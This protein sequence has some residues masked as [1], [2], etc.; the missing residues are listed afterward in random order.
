[1]ADVQ[2]E[3]DKLADVTRHTQQHPEDKVAGQGAV[4]FVYVGSKGPAGF[5]AHDF[6]QQRVKGKTLA[7]VEVVGT[8]IEKTCD[9]SGTKEPYPCDGGIPEGGLGKNID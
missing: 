1:M 3:A 9:D 8:V 2:G 5:G 7:K 6:A 4:V